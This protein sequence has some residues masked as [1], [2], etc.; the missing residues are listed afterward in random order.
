MSSR[1]DTNASGSDIRPSYALPDVTGLAAQDDWTKAGNPKERKKLQNRV[2]QRIYRKDVS[3]FLT[4][5]LY[6]DSHQVNE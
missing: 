1:T 6:T 5:N 4:S 3:S 2:A